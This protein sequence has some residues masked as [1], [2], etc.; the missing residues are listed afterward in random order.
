[1]YKKPICEPRCPERKPGCHATCERFKKWRYEL[2]Q[3]K[4]KEIAGKDKE[5]R[6][7]QVLYGRR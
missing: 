4:D 6:L 3:D 7:N 5:R 2:L 1:M